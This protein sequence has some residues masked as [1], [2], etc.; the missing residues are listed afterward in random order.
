VWTHIACSGHFPWLFSR[1]VKKL[2]PGL[3]GEVTIQP[4]LA[5]R[6]DF[7]CAM[8]HSSPPVCEETVEGDRRMDWKTLLAYITG[9]VD[10]ELLMRNEYLVTG[11]RILRNQ[12]KGRE[13]FVGK[14]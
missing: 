6:L 4:L 3:T 11:N 2:E 7:S 9:T 13:L 8:S 12:L 10:Q 14:G 1:M 5:P